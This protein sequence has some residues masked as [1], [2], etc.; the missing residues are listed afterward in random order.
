M[1]DDHVV[2]ARD[3]PPDYTVV[4]HRRGRTSLRCRVGGRW[5][6][7]SL[8]PGDVSLLTRDAEPLWDRPAGVEVV[9]VP[10]SRTALARAGREMYGRDV[11]DIELRDVIRTED[12]AIHRTAL[13]IGDETE[14]GATGSGLMVEALSSQIAV[15]VLRRHARV[16]LREPGG[17]EA[18]TFAQERRVR[19]H[20]HRNLDASLTLDELAAVAGMSRFRFARRFRL[21]T[22][23]TP[24]EFV[25][26]AR[27]GRARVLLERSATPLFEVAARCGFADQ[28]HLTREFRKRTG[29]T[30]GRYRS[31]TR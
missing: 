2:P 28:S 15:H 1:P 3:L 26:Q 12:P 27:V 29:T 25:L 21:T 23:T 10:L 13:L 17:T 24:H 16:R 14:L 18:L 6:Q 8:G 22:G 30:P 4:A 9:Q 5:R 7:E 11:A 31:G 20:V 19:D